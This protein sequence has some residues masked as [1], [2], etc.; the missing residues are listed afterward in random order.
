MPHCVRVFDFCLV[1][2]I[3]GYRDAN[4]ATSSELLSVDYGLLPISSATGDSLFLRTQALVVAATNQPKTKLKPS[5]I[6]VAWIMR[7]TQ[8]LDEL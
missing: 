5:Q 3:A 8:R 2:A 4:V 1:P 7:N 6:F